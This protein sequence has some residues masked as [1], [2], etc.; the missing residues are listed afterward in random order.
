[1]RRLNRW[2]VVGVVII[3]LGFAIWRLVPFMSNVHGVQA[4]PQLR[5][6]ATT[7]ITHAVFI[8]LENHSFDNL[9]GRFPGVN[10][11]QLSQAA[12][13]ISSDFGHSGPA[14]LA[15]MDGGK[16]D[17]FP[18]RSYIQYSQSDIPNTW[19]YAKQY[20]LGDNFF[21]SAATNSTP[22]HMTWL[23][24]QTGGIFDSSNQT[25]CTSAHNNLVYSKNTSGNQYWSYP[26][27]GIYSL[28]QEL[29]TA[30]VSWKYYSGTPIWDA[31]EMLQPIFS[32]PDY[33]TKVSVPGQFITDVQSGNLAN[34]SWVTP[35]GAGNQSDHPPVALQGAQN[36]ITQQ[37][38]AIMNS[39]YWSST[40]IFVT[41]DDWG[42]FY[43]HVVPPQLDGVGLG[44]RVPL[45]VIS[46]YAKQNYISHK[47]GEFAS[48]MKFVES[49][50]N[51][52]NIGQRDSLSQI[53][54]LMDYFDFSQT[55]QS[56]LL[57]NTLSYS[58]ALVVPGGVGGADSLQGA[59][60]PIV[61]GTA[62]VYQY[63]VVYTLN[64]TP[65]IHTITIDGVAHTMTY[66]NPVKGGYYYTY[67]TKLPVGKHNFTFTFSDTSGTLTLP[68]NGVPFPGPEVHPFNATTVGSGVTPG[69]V[70]PGQTVTY[71][72]TY[73]S[74]ANKPAT[75]AEVDIDG[76]PYAMQPTGTNYAAGVVYTYTTTS[77]VPGQH[78]HRFRFD[79]GSGVAVYESSVKPMVTPVVLAQSSVSPTS[80]TS[81]TVFT[82]QTTYTESSGNAPAHAKLYID[83]KPYTMT[84]V[85]GNY[86][87]GAVYQYQTTLSSGNHSFYFVFSDTASS[88][89]D[90]FAP[91]TYAGPNVG[92]HVQAVAPGT[93]IIPDH[94]VNPD[95]G[96]YVGPVDSDG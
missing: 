17:E 19:A 90:P 71:A 49:D 70:M 15:A 65:A 12:N 2:Y 22:N 85:S 64:Q 10:G 58:Q 41:W 72:I 29:D 96:Q 44:P 67:K 39:Q 80:G 45:I 53:S 9:F 13:P 25:G 20:G 84:Y 42:G 69:V 61:G 92:A 51:I 56:P 35:P 28:P 23:A 75:L 37:V 74:P 52:Q 82:F 4:N 83:N 26:C 76:V 54:D 62:T 6:S 78:Y 30:S 73:T 38:N 59:L 8:M 95:L 27:Y 11:A 18:A 60:L 81:S 88:W 86:G 3:V 63:N 31:P 43:D 94:T 21:S 1:M 48:F 40:A 46:P 33:K 93:L 50:F 7:P 36:F 77:L 24:G 87:T 91:T 16:M 47:L 5:A 66:V 34:V 32:S 57:L 68:Y 14:A 55:P 79:D 89:A